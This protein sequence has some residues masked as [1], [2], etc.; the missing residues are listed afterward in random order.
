MQLAVA[1]ATY[2]LQVHAGCMM[3]LAGAGRRLR[4][5]LEVCSTL[6]TGGCVGGWRP[7]LVLGNV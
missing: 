1:G 5:R 3:Q 2:R 4:M 7:I 6:L